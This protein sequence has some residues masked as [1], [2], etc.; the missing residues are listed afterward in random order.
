M[1]AP[2][3]S[4]GGRLIPTL[5]EMSPRGR[6]I[7][8]AYYE[9]GVVEGIARGRDQ[10]NAEWCA[11]DAHAFAVA[12]AAAD[13]PPWAELARRRNDHTRA[14]KQVATLRERGVVA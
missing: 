11:A 5:A 7:A 9:A 8:T 1:S 13:S 14:A 4:G 6:E 2:D 10:L 3:A 12:R